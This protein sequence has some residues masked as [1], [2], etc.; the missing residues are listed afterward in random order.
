MLPFEEKVGKSREIP[1][2]HDLQEL[3]D[4]PKG[5]PLFQSA[6][7]RKRQLTGTAIHVNDIC[8]LMK[9]HLKDFRMPLLYSSHSFRVTTITDLLEHNVAREDV[10][11]LARHADPRTTNLYDSRGRKIK[12]N[13]MDRISV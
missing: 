9:R 8:R 11:H 1:V 13:I 6:L 4:A 10:Q 2:R 3:R 7:K 5:A 12:R